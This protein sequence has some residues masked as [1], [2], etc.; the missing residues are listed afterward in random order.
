[1]MARRI[2]GLLL[3]TLLCLPACT[4]VVSTPP[5]GGE[6]SPRAPT[7][8]P[9]E[10][11]PWWNDRV[12]YEVFVRSFYDGDGDGVGD[13]QGLIA[14]LDYL[15][16]GDPATRGD[17]GITGLWL[18]PVAES[19]SYHGYDVV[20][21]QRIEQD[22]GTND[23]FRQL[24]AAAHRRGVVV[25]V[26]FVTNHTSNQHPW[27]LD[28]Q[29]PGSAHED[30]YIWRDDNPGYAG[31]WGQLVWHEAGGR[32]YYGLFW[33][34]MPDLN[35]GNPAVTAA[36]YDVARFWLEEMGVDGFRLDAVRHLI[37]D[38]Q[39][40]ENTPATH[41][42]LEGF[43]DH[44]RAV[45]PDALLVGEIWSPS[46]A[47]VPYVGD[48]VDIA[49]EF[50]LASAIVHS[51]RGGD[52]SLLV[53]TQE[54]VLELYPLGQYAAFLTNHDQNRV[55]SELG[56]NVEAAKLAATLLLTNPGV[57]FLYYGEEIGMTGAKPDERIRTPMQWEG[58][59]PGV[60]FTT[61]T[62]W[63][64]PQPDY[65]DWNV[66]AQHDDPASLLS[67]YR[68]LIALRQS[69]PALRVGDF[70]MVESDVNAVYAYLRAAPDEVLL[71][72]V[73]LSAEAVTD[74][75]LSLVQGPLAGEVD[76]ALLLGEGQPAAPVVNSSGG[77]DAY[78]PLPTLPPRSSFIIRLTP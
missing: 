5:T 19:P 6:P 64:P 8:R 15:N 77:F 42:W 35:Y 67:R 50:D 30:W 72:L 53:Y 74:Y 68:A 78:V 37:E 61:G 63:Q 24:I 16:D 3:L 18:M 52:K 28:A 23:D 40:Q 76:A 26:D 11:L 44:V 56:G 12:F 69:H 66:A 46:V 22:Y 38:G 57:P 29:T 54:R 32:Y 41:A 62:P 17:L 71:V 2:V 49:F 34:G 60:G 25:I 33:S 45:N 51:V 65:A 21:Y 48:E 7:A 4:E 9:P 58:A 73:N 39:T 31:P 70:L 13:L 10:S 1:M 14:K 75:R 43:H 36:M 59:S 27:F 55:M 20:D 47:V